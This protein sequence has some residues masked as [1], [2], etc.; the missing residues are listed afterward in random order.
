MEPKYRSIC[1]LHA[2]WSQTTVR[3]VPCALLG[4]KRLFDLSPA[5]CMGPNDCSICSN[6]SS[7]GQSKGRDGICAFPSFAPPSRRVRAFK[8]SELR[9]AFDCNAFQHVCAGNGNLERLFAGCRLESSP[10]PR[11]V[12]HRDGITARRVVE[13]E[14]NAVF[15]AGDGRNAHGGNVQPRGRARVLTRRRCGGRG[16]PPSPRPYLKRPVRADLQSALRRL[17]GRSG[18]LDLRE[19]GREL[20]RHVA[21]GG[22][23]GGREYVAADCSGMRD[24]IVGDALGPRT[25]PASRGGT[26]V[27][28]ADASRARENRCCEGCRQ[29]ALKRTENAACAAFSGYMRGGGGG[30]VFCAF[31]PLLLRMS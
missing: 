10:F 19:R 28:P 12:L 22:R 30:E 5:R 14:Q 6:R 18:Y 27:N 21:S 4:A 29:N 23:R 9:L 1:S 15:R 16:R 31:S 11:S 20:Q 17:V 25:R 8:R 24:G 3:L 7:W 26:F 13:D 2:A